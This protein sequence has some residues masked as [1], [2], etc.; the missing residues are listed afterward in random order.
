[1]CLN[2]S[3]LFLYH[4]LELKAQRL[5]VLPPPTNET[6]EKMISDNK[7]NSEIVWCSKHLTDDDMATIAF[8]LIKGNKVSD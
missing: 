3:F 1:M 5:L 7:H 2:D 8:Y 4:Y 6:L